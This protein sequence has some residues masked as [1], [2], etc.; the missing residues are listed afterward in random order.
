LVIALTFASG[1]PAISQDF[2][3]TTIKKITPQASDALVRAL[4]DNLHE[5]RTAEISNN[6]RFRHFLAQILTETGG[7][8][9]LDENMNYSAQR[10]Q[11]VFKVEEQISLSIA[12]D[13]KRVANYVYG[14]KLGNRGRDTDDGWNFRGSG[15]IQLTGRYNFRMRGREIDQPLEGQPDLARRPREG[16]LAALAYWRA[17]SINAAAD[18]NEIQAVRR[19]I[20]P[21]LEGLAASRKWLNRINLV[22]SGF[23]AGEAIDADSEEILRDLGLLKPMGAESGQGDPTAALRDYQRSRGLAETGQVDMET[24]Y[25]LT[26]PQEW[27]SRASPSSGFEDPAPDRQLGIVFD[28]ASKQAA[29]LSRPAAAVSPGAASSGSSTG[30]SPNATMT[31]EALA[32]A[33]EARPLFPAYEMKDYAGATNNNF[34]P[35]SVIEPDTREVVPL[36]TEYPA[37]TV[38]HISFLPSPG[39]SRFACTGAMISKNTVLTAGHCVHSGGAQGNW[40]QDFVVTPGRNGPIAPFGACKATKLLSLSGWVGSTSDQEARLVDLGAIKLDCDVGNQVGW[41]SMRGLVD[42]SNMDTVIRG[43]PCDKA[44]VGKQWISSG[45]TSLIIGSKLFYQNDTYG[46]MSGAPIIASSDGKIVGVHTN[47]LHGTEPWSSNNAGTRLLVSPLADI[48]AFSGD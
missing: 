37:R 12:G 32:A 21:P 41:L 8:R 23:E 7:L 3:F 34:V 25:S 40:H 19:L 28:I 11:D 2:D 4:V 45:R 24:F 42:D 39:A 22:V 10:I 1:A 20:N 44:P 26:D 6:L 35:F 17:R 29:P 43:Y 27:R 47:G 30:P 14:N 33:N 18:R 9:R 48:Q 36:T 15:Y 16:L 46:C 13:P 31:S 38:V 5:I